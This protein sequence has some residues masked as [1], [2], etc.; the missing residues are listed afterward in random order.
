VNTFYKDI[1]GQ[2]E[3][4]RSNNEIIQLVFFYQLFDPV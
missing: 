2:F 1:R 3:I 4:S